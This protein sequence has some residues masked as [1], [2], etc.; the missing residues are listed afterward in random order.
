MGITST[1]WPLSLCTALSSHFA[2]PSERRSEKAVG[3]AS[4][5][6][7][8][9]THPKLGTLQSRL[10]PLISKVQKN[11]INKHLYTNK[12]Y[13]IRVYIY[14]IKKQSIS[15]I[16]NMTSKVGCSR[17]WPQEASSRE[18]PKARLQQSTGRDRTGPGRL[19]QLRV[20]SCICGVGRG[21]GFRGLG[22]RV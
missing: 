3:A 14:V 8:P 5:P 18:A 4:M 20:A 17:I 6:P 22:F 10:L 13:S 15:I 1:S 11:T 12:Q 2:G 9:W 21:L 16:T 19:W 7:G